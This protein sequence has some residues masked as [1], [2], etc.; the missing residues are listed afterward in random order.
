MPE[1]SRKINKFYENIKKKGGDTTEECQKFY[2]EVLNNILKKT[3]DVD[4]QVYNS[5]N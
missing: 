3:K 1:T 2:D 5:K 4:D